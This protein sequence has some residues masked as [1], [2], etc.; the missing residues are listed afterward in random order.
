[1]QHKLEFM[2]HIQRQVS[3]VYDHLAQPANLLGLQPLLSSISS[4]QEI[5]VDNKRGFNYETVETFRIGPIPV[6]NNRIRVQTVLTEPNRQIDSIVQSKPNIRLDVHYQFTSL[7]DE[8]AVVEQM[9]ISVPAWVSAYV[10]ATARRV[11]EQTLDNLKHRLEANEILDGSL[12]IDMTT[13]PSS[14]DVS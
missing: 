7:G 14:K 6:L 12:Q 11:Q 13:L 3:V 10:V 2:V 5:E 9:L 4:V 1:M 8:T